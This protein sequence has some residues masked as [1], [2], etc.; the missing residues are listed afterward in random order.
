[1]RRNARAGAPWIFWPIAALWD[2]V[3]F[4]LGLTGRLIGIVLALVLM[5]GSVLLGLTVIGLP[6]AIPLFIVALALLVRS[7][8]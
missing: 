3:A 2:L 1:M 8:F 7:L 4:V 5:L 6:I